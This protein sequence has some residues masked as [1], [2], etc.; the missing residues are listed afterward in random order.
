LVIAVVLSVIYLAVQLS[1]NSRLLRSQSHYNTL[2]VSQRALEIVIASDTLAGLLEQCDADPWSVPG[3]I[4]T[5]CV[6]Y[7]FMQVN[8]W[9]YTYHQDLEGSTPH[10]LWVGVGG[11]FSNEARSNA[12]WARFWRDTAEAF[13]EPFRSYLDERLRQNPA[14][15]HPSRASADGD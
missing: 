4:W 15:A 5:R 6:N 3:A 11:Y 14:F 7:V 13:G 10:S 8:P 9:E 2:E 12:S 1:D